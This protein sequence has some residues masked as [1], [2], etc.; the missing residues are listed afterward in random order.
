MPQNGIHSTSQMLRA[1]IRT[2]PPGSELARRH[3]AIDGTAQCHRAK[4]HDEIHLP[5]P[6]P[7]GGA[8]SDF[9]Q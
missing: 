4:G 5:C 2:G 9:K 7:Y 3:S 6:A 8:E 1:L